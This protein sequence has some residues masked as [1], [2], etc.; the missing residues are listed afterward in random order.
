MQI[1][2]IQDSNVKI[3][4]GSLMVHIFNSMLYYWHM[5][6]ITENSVKQNLMW[7]MSEARN[8]ILIKDNNFCSLHQGAT[9]GSCESFSAHIDCCY[10]GSQIVRCLFFSPLFSWSWW[11]SVFAAQTFSSE[12][13]K[14]KSAAIFWGRFLCKVIVS[15]KYVSVVIPYHWEPKYVSSWVLDVR[16]LVLG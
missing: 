1:N 16:F 15:F 14:T 6:N 3:Q 7:L 2:S 9:W 5:A 12:A 8:F 10:S 13:F 11:N 4:A